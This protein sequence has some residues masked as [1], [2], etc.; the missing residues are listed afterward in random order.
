MNRIEI[1]FFI[2]GISVLKYFISGGGD[3]ARF[4][5]MRRNATLDVQISDFKKI[6]E[7][8]HC[9]YTV[10]RDT[11]NIAINKFENL[12]EQM[13]PLIPFLSDES[14]KQLSD[15][16]GGYEEPKRP[17]FDS[18]N[19]NILK[20]LLSNAEEFLA[21]FVL[22]KQH[23]SGTIDELLNDINTLLNE[24]GGDLEKETVEMIENTIQNLKILRNIKETYS[25]IIAQEE[26]QI[27]S[28]IEDLVVLKFTHCS[29][30]CESKII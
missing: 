11:A 19:C 10:I 9:N 18:G 14:L 6:L 7:E 16:L 23:H 5:A 3:R 24:S 26:V 21:I 1:I 30:E 22:Q 28:L 15:I 25:L 2:I 27:L 12:K 20:N 17:S 8:F 29:S 4:Q 13:S